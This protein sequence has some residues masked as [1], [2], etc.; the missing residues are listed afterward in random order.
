MKQVVNFFKRNW[1]SLGPIFKAF[2][3]VVAVVAGIYGAANWIDSRARNAV[4][5]ETILAK[6]T[7]RV[8]PLCVFNS[9]GAIEL[10]VGASEY[11]DTT[12]IRI[13][14]VPDIYGFSIEIPA[15]R[16]LAYPPLLS[17]LDVSLFPEKIERGK[18]NDW[19]VIL[20][21]QSTTP[22]LLADRVE[23]SKKPYRFKLEILH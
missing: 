17:G 4:V 15:K 8:R 7:I 18:G 5:D 2:V 13:T 16:H 19:K 11:I 1:E 9:N 22:T 20:A 21:P 23:M 6:L 10:D 14:P 3:A 12:N